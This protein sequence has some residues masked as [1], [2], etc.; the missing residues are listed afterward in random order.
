[1]PTRAQGRAG[2]GPF[3]ALLILLSLLLGAGNAAAGGADLRGP[4]A[5]SGASRGGAATALL[6]SATRNPLDDEAAGADGASPVPA[7]APGLVTRI[8]WARPPAGTIFDYPAPVP[9]ATGASQRARA[10]PAS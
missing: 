5:R 2:R 10:P 3:G 7:R 1:M 8:L 9:R 6:P 4:A